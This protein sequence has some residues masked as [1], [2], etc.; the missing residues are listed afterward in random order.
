[1]TGEAGDVREA[2]CGCS[3][4]CCRPRS[5]VLG[6]DHP[7]TLRARNRIAVMTDETHDAREAPQPLAELRPAHERVLGRDHRATIRTRL[8]RTFA[9]VVGIERYG[10]PGSDL[11]GPARDACRFVRW[12]QS[13]GVP[14]GN[15][16]LFASPLEVNAAELEG[17]DVPW[18][19]ASREPIHEYFTKRLPGMSGDLLILFWSGHG[20][21]TA[22]ERRL[23]F[24]DATQVATLNLDLYSLL[25][26]LHGDLFAGLPRQ[27]A[28]IDACANH[29]LETLREPEVFPFERYERQ[30]EQFV[31]VRGLDLGRWRRMRRP[32]SQGLLRRGPGRVGTTVPPDFSPDF[33]ALEERLPDR[34]QTLQ[35]AGRTDQTP[36]LYWSLD[37]G[38]NSETAWADTRDCRSVGRETLESLQSTEDEIRA[39][40]RPLMIDRDTRRARLIRAFGAYP[41]LLDRI[42]IDSAPAVFLELLIN[43]LREYGEA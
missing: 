7:D 36:V 41:G 29:K 35:K 37:W 23:I 33:S 16:Q 21:L 20:I 14:S 31:L 32:G 10:I 22:E 24:S 28:I 26:S 18:Q 5:R 27:V 40:L 6:R 13:R 8:A 9:V 19:A 43:T 2:A 34:F 30:C 3:E 1:M 25:N 11:A 39:V 17:L 42:N 38:G 15:I 12:L 4:S